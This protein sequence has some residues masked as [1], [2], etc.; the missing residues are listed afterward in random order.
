MP[1][2]RS[3]T[4]SLAFVAAL[5]AAGVGCAPIAPTVVRSAPPLAL[6]FAGAE[7][8]EPNVAAHCARSLDQALTR[9]GFLMGPG[10]VP[11]RV[12]VAF[13]NQT[14]FGAGTGST[15]SADFT[16]SSRSLAPDETVIASSTTSLTTFG[17]DVL[18]PGVPARFTACTYGSERFAETLAARLSR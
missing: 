14:F 3:S 1:T 2:P 16:G 18:W 4:T 6:V 9:H 5:L 13:W 15:V 12:H 8:I 11:L 17:G 7:D 10:G